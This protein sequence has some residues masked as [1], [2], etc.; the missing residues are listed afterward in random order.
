MGIQLALGVVILVLG[1]QW[2]DQKLGTSPWIMIAGIMLGTV[3]GIIKFVY[4][5]M[6]IGREEDNSEDKHSDS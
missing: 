1:G 6:E 5:A 2:L 4:G 3:G